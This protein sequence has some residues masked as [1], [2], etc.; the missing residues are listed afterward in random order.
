MHMRTHKRTMALELSNWEK[1]DT[2]KGN[3]CWTSTGWCF[4]RGSNGRS[5]GAEVEL[6]S[7][8][9][10][11]RCLTDNCLKLKGKGQAGIEEGTGL[12]F[13]RSEEWGSSL[14]ERAWWE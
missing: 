11:W 4:G 3:E 7:G 8:A 6:L 5:G 14:R 9:P 2:V 1:G 12:S 10:V 13:H